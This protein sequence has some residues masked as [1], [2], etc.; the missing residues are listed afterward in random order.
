MQTNIQGGF[1]G[2]LLISVLF[3]LSNPLIAQSK[4]SINLGLRV[5]ISVSYFGETSQFEGGNPGLIAGGEIKY[6]ISDIIGAGAEVLYHQQRGKRLDMNI[7]AAG[8]IRL[9][10]R[11][12]TINTLEIPIL[13]SIKLLQLNSANIQLKPGYSFSYVMGVTSRDVIHSFTDPGYSQT[14][15]TEILTSDYAKDQHA[16]IGALVVE[17]PVEAGFLKNL[18]IDFRYRQGLSNIETTYSV[19][20]GQTDPV[21]SKSIQLVM[22]FSF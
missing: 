8:G 7:T 19:L 15:G 4:S 13:A 6:N 14:R 21:Y 2:C 10:E 3:L 5:G 20:R 17:I 22:G 1:I 16:V 12:I 18:S 11:N 9:V